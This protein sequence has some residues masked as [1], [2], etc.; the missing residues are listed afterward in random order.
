MKRLKNLWDKMHP[1]YNFLSDKNL[2]DQASR[3]HRNNV[4]MDTEYGEASTSITRND[5]LCTVT[6]NG[7]NYRYID[8]NENIA[9]EQVIAEK[10]PNENLNDEQLQLVEKLKPSFNKNFETFKLQTIEQR[11]YTTKIDKKIQTDYL[12]A[13][14]TV[15]REHLAN[16]GNITF[17]D[18]NVSIY[19]TAVTIKQDLN[20]LK[21]I[22]RNINAYNTSPRWMIKFEDSINRMRKKIGQIHT[23]ISCKKSNTFTEHQPSLKNKFQ[24]KYGNTKTHVHLNIN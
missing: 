10:I 24:K 15:A 11:V 9:P 21:E 17:W 1:E 20:D 14:N 19:T 23:L 16:I 22:N 4:V 12:K 13:I 8:P 18:I 7:N 2:R 5:N 3:I 6:G